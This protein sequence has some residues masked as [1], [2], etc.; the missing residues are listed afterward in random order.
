MGIDLAFFQHL[1]F[2]KNLN[3]SIN[4]ENTIKEENKFSDNISNDPE[5]SGI[6]WKKNSIG[7]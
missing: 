7:I 5:F 2:Q 6:A 3:S 4:E 1:G